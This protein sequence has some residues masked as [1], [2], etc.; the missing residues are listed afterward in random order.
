MKETDIQN[1][2]ALLRRIERSLVENL[3][4]ESICCGISFNECHV[5]LEVEGK[6]STA[7]SSLSDVLG[8]DKSMV[9]RTVDTLVQ[10]GMLIRLEDPDDRRRKS[11]VL[12]AEGEKM[13]EWING[14]M[15]GKYRELFDA[16]GTDTARALTG[17]TRLLAE[18]LELWKDELS[19]ASVCCREEEE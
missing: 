10:R 8:M 13:A 17:A 6:P 18:T 2:R 9:S 12:S 7:V 14:Q 19:A 3:K 15:N 11:L 16:L 1:F 4:G 5:L